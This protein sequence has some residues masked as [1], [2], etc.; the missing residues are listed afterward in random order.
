MRNAWW[1]A[2]WFA[3]DREATLPT[4]QSASMP[5][6]AFESRDVIILHQDL[7]SFLVQHVGQLCMYYEYQNTFLFCL[8]SIIMFRN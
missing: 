8:F 3:N 2:L 6:R 4:T 5:I 1:F 7:I